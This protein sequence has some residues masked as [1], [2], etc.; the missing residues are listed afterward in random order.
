M[1]NIWLV[2]ALICSIDFSLVEI[3][4]NTGNGFSSMDNDDDDD[5]DNVDDDLMN[6]HGQQ[7]SDALV[8]RFFDDDFDERLPMMNLQM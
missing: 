7:T 2:F 6:L 3:R 4:S 8:A 1:G 5:V